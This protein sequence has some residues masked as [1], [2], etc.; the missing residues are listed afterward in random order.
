[1]KESRNQAL[2]IVK[3][4]GACFVIFIH[5]HFAKDAGKIMECLARFAVPFFF[6]AAGYYAYRKGPEI[7]AKRM[8]RILKILAGASAVF[9]IWGMISLGNGYNTSLADYFAARLTVGSIARLLFLDCNP[10][11]GHLWFL[12]ALFFAYLICFLYVNCTASGK[13]FHYRPLYYA[14]AAALI[15]HVILSTVLMAC[16]ITLNYIFY[17]NTWLFSFPMFVMGLFLHEYR[18]QIYKRFHLSKTCLLLII[19]AGA[20]ISLIQRFL[21]GPTELPVGTIPEVAALILLLT[22]ENVCRESKG[23]NR[24]IAWILGKATLFIYVL[25]PLYDSILRY[26]FPDST[27]LFS[28]Q[29]KGY[30]PLLILALSAVIGIFIAYLLKICGK[31]KNKT[32]TAK[33]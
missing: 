6:A 26:C 20:G 33:S 29:A 7:I 15:V 2:D 16:G 3:F 22:D 9:L 12:S 32:E 17:R 23:R 30:Y 10:F 13:A 14:G 31:I 21:L 27:F 5:I 4:I 19:A 11:G 1:M 24:D 8:L 18:E 25:H 28:E